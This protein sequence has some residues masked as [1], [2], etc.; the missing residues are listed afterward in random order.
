MGNYNPFYKAS[1]LVAINI[2]LRRPQK[3]Y[4]AKSGTH[5]TDRI[6]YDSIKQ[7]SS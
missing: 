5:N 2:H 6:I 1:E 7:R 3:W 4:I